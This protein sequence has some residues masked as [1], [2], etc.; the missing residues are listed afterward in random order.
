MVHVA[1]VMAATACKLLAD[2]AL[3][4]AAKADHAA[5][6]ALSLS[7]PDTRRRCSSP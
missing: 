2:D 6:R 1:K 5:H 4:V 7:L 3:L